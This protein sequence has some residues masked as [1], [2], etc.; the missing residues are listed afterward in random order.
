[1]NSYIFKEAYK[2][3]INHLIFFSCSIMYHN[4]KKP[5]REKDFKYNK[6]INENTSG[7]YLLIFF[8]AVLTTFRLLPHPPNFTPIIAAAI[9]GPFFFRS[10]IFAIFIVLF[11]M[12]IS[13]IFLGF[14]IY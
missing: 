13:D 4:S 7:I 9:V 11:S 6:K 1:M 3:N 10:K 5:L 12:F 2:S 14:H 8:I